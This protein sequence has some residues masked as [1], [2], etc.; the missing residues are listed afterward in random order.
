MADGQSNPTTV[1]TADGVSRASKEPNQGKQKNTVLI[2]LVISLVL[3]LLCCCCSF[4]AGLSF[5]ESVMKEVGPEIQKDLEDELK[6]ELEKNIDSNEFYDI[7]DT[8]SERWG[9]SM[10]SSEDP[11]I[12]TGAEGDLLSSD[13]KLIAVELEVRNTATYAQT[14]PEYLLN[15]IDNQN[16]KYYSESLVDKQPELTGDL[17]DPGKTVA[18]WVVFIVPKDSEG[19]VL[20]YDDSSGESPLQFEI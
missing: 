11:F 19:L 6:R 4:F 8:T 17:I 10:L 14:F 15:L 2:I 9:V 18:G 5:T 20:E 13:E 3:L 12:Y 7:F 1:T 16:T